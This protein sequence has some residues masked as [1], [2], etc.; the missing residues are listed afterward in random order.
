MKM[1]VYVPVFFNG[2]VSVVMTS[3]GN[4]M[5]VDMGVAT[6]IYIMAHMSFIG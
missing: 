3:L 5:S 6:K 1:Q 2:L 4:D